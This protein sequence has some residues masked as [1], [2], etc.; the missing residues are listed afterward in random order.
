MAKKVAK[1][2]KKRTAKKKTVKKE[3]TDP[4]EEIQNFK[5]EVVVPSPVLYSHFE[6]TTHPYI[7][8]MALKRLGFDRVIDLTTSSAAM[9]RALVK[10]M[11]NYRGH[12]PLISSFWPSG[13]NRAYPLVAEA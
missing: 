2:K 1:T 8:H 3:T 11:K 10:Y 9:A 4:V 13:V 12:R 7:I 6:W 5:Y